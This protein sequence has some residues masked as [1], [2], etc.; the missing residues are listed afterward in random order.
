MMRERKN[1]KE[2][3]ENYRKNKVCRRW[4][5]PSLVMSHDLL[6]IDSSSP[7]VLG[8]YQSGFVSYDKTKYK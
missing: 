3:K 1:Y 6:K 7:L 2:R 5:M 4:R 8:D